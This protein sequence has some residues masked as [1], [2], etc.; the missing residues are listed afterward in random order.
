MGG[1]IF[2]FCDMHR[3]TECSSSITEASP[4]HAT[5]DTAAPCKKKRR[6]TLALYPEHFPDL[7]L[8]SQCRRISAGAQARQR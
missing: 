7:A 2:R 8:G 4:H 3:R 1:N 6:G 5:I